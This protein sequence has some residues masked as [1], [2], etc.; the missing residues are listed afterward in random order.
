ML[1]RIKVGIL[2]AAGLICLSALVVY[3]A[4]GEFAGKWKGEMKAAAVPEGAPG[5]GAGGRGGFGGGGRGGFGG[6]GPQKVSLNLKHDAKTNKLSGN[7]VL[8]DN[9]AYDVKDGIVE[10]NKIYFKAGRAP[11]PIYEYSGVMLKE[12]ELTLTRKADGARGRPVEYILKR[13]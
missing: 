3:A 11:Q 1:N 5:A 7:F 2:L 6:G 12:D 13:S 4:D 9:D 8:G 10:G